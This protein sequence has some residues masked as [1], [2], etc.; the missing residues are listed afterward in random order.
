MQPGPA[1]LQ[2][3]DQVLRRDRS[4]RRRNAAKFDTTTA[5]C[6]TT[7]PVLVSTQEYRRNVGICLVN[8]KGLVF[9]ARRVDDTQGTWQ[10]PQGGID[11]C[12]NP[13]VAAARELLEE[14]GIRSIEFVAQID[15]WIDYEFPTTVQ[16]ALTGCWT[17]YKGQ[18]QK[19][20]LF[21]FCG[22]DSEIDLDFADKEFLEYKWAEL[23]DLPD[24]VVY[25]KQHVYQLV[26]LEFGPYI[27]RI[28]KAGTT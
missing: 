6:L 5:Q 19:W 13:F 1:H 17:K 10:M 22:S 2:V 21:K 16:S 7:K 27:E 28:K 24:K 20:M 3:S 18:T 4:L 8:S 25:F 9:A 26:V 11:P 15:Q 23:H 12:E 14:T